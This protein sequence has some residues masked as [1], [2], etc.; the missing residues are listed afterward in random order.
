MTCAVFS[1]LRAALVFLRHAD[2]RV[3]DRL[4]GGLLAERVDVA[5][6]VLDVANV[7][8]DHPQADL[9]ELDLD[10]LGDRGDEFLAVVVDLLDGHRGEHDAHLAHHDLGRQVLDLL[11][12]AA[13]EPRR[14][15]LH[16]LGVGRDA[17]GERRRGI[18]ADVLARERALEL[19]LDVHRREVQVAV[20]L[21]ERDHERRAAVIALGGLAVGQLAVHDQDAVGRTHAVARDQRDDDDQE[22]DDDEAD[23]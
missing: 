16:D 17:D 20:A 1:P 14:G 3:V 8:V 22:E 6:E 23:G 19:D 15:V 10:A 13:Q 2:L 18:N 11:G 5:G 4:G 21:E 7:A 9:V 12:R